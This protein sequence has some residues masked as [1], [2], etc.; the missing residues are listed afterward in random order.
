M[1]AESLQLGNGLFQGD[2]GDLAIPE[3]RHPAVAS[4]QHKPCRAGPEPETEDAVKG[5]WPTRAL[6]MAEH[7]GAGLPAQAPLDLVGYERRDP[8]GEVLAYM[9]LV[10]GRV[11]FVCML[12]C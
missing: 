12:V 11:G 5:N 10:E 8:P 9:L 2:V 7:K 3:G 4:L 6:E 1:L